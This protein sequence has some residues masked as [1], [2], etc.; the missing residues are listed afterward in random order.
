[1]ARYEIS[2]RADHLERLVHPRAPRPAIEELIWNALDAD[3]DLVD[4]RFVTTPLGAVED[5]IIRDDGH[6]IP[7]GTCDSAFRNLGDS[8]KKNAAGTRDK[9]RSLH[10]NKGEGRFR[11]FALG[12]NAVWT[13]VADDVD[14]RRRRSRIEIKRGSLRIFETGDP[15]ETSDPPGTTV[16]ISVLDRQAVK[17]LQSDQMRRHLTSTFAVYL[18]QYPDVRIIY[19]GEPLDA[20]TLQI[21][22]REYQLHEP[23]EATL[24]V[25][26]WDDAH[27]KRELFLCTSSGVTIHR[28]RPDIVAPGF[29]FTAYLCW[30]GF[31]GSRTDLFEADMR[32]DEV[33]QVVEAAR[34]QL[35]THF[36]DRTVERGQQ[37]V[38]QWQKEK[39]YPFP[40]E[41]EPNELSATRATFDLVATSI[42]G[43]LPAARKAKRISLRLLREALAGGPENLYR[44]LNDVIKLDDEKRDEL[45][46]LLRRVEL[47]A[48]I[49]A[50]T[51]V[52]SRLDFLA[53]LEEMVF[54]P[55]AR[56]MVLERSQLH[57]ILE[58][59]TWVFGEEYGLIVSDRS[60]REVLRRHLHRLGR[61]D[62]TD[63]D[64]LDDQGRRRIV[65]MM[66]SGAD[67]KGGRQRHLIV[68]LKRPSLRLTLDEVLQI[69]RYANAVM[70]DPRF[71]DAATWDFWLI[72]TEMDNS[73]ARRASQPH[74]PPGCAT[75]FGNG[76]RL[77][78]RTWQ[79]L[80]DDC[81]DRLHYFVGHLEYQSDHE[82]AAQYLVRKHGD[83]VPKLMRPTPSG[84]A[85]TV[86][87]G[88]A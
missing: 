40:P 4:V 62:F 88:R 32:D 66:L 72:G 5:I 65:D 15:E 45:A 50:S 85:G 12:R 19:D 3:A 44:A 20:A 31:N 83:R 86:S 24:K 13:T 52:M 71:G 10:G 34:N 43:H 37:Q 69:E 75:D 27:I 55:E 17:A 74:L 76:T 80:I 9:G 61:D 48:I 16:Q 33:G 59:E 18:T 47:S 79:E 73:V 56:R 26:E 41:P 8:W 2:V 23:V 42:A 81:R 38:E 7:P 84:P 6:G 29:I 64:V 60:L 28:E 39:V 57:K 11:A 87:G 53:A 68:E 67:R 25:I 78:V 36:T 49:R 1:M 77:W 21:H 58:H 14:G 35:V 82:H 22:S 30:E 46:E 54:D 51:S 70:D 63:R